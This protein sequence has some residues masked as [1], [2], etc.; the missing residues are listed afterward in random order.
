MGSKIKIAKHPVH[1]MLVPIPIGLWIFSF[2]CDLIYLLGSKNP[3]W[4]QVALY[5]MIGGVIGALLA[6]VPGFIDFLSFKDPKIKKIGAFHLGLNLFAVLLFGFN[7]GLRFNGPTSSTTP[8]ILSLVGIVVLGVSGWLGG[9]M[10]YVHG[11]GVEP[12]KGVLEPE[13][14]LRRNLSHKNIP[15]SQE[16]QEHPGTRHH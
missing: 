15:E 1:P 7:A 11:V 10:V 2:V 3:V 4:E 13:S 16:Q 12:E 14:D 8:I 9:E 5:T 6:A